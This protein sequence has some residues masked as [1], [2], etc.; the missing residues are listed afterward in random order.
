M[1]RYTAT[2]ALG[3]GVVNADT[4][5]TRLV[6]DQA[7]RLLQTIDPRG[8]ATTAI[9]DDYVTAYLYDGLGRLVLTVDALGNRTTT[10]YDDLGNRTVIAL[11][12]GLATTFVYDKRGLLISQS[13]TDTRNTVTTSDDIP[14]GT[15]IYQ[16]DDNGRLRL[17]TDPEGSETHYLYDEAGRLI[18]TLDPTGALAET[19]YDKAGNV[20]Q[21]IGYANRLSAST[22]ASLT[23]LNGNPVTFDAL[24]RDAL[25][26]E[27][28]TVEDRTSYT[29]YDTANRPV[30]VIDALGYVTQSFY[31]GAGRITD[32]VDYATATTTDLSLLTQLTPADIVIIED[33]ADDRHTRYFYDHGGNRIASLDAAGFL[34]EY[35]YD[36][37]GQRTE[38]I[39]YATRLADAGLHTNGTLEAIR[40]A[41]GTVAGDRRAY[42][43]YNARG[44]TAVAI[45][46][47]GYLTV[48]AYD[49]AG[50]RNYEARYTNPVTLTESSTLASLIQVASGPHDRVTTTVYTARNQVETVTV[51]TVS[52]A[53]GTG[54]VT[55]Y[56][57]DAVGNLIRTTR[58]L[59]T[60]EAR[61]TEA[62]YDVQA[63][64][65]GE[66]TGEGSAAL[67]QLWT[68]IPRKR[69]S[70]PC[71][72]NTA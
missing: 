48:W 31:D 3:N 29:L 14:L 59:N 4:A 52:G 17:I 54:T 5:T 12:N 62:R 7:G 63:N 50:N 33:A 35:R 65:I 67:A 37:A 23:D 8:E 19:V 22:I 41:I 6:Y 42:T 53:P 56:E 64:L 30:M 40:L 18:L 70:M 57:Y 15:T 9:S 13:E 49:T 39:G 46:A 21:S 16:Y 20:I 71:G 25:R 27:A 38:T 36:A 72:S 45:D 26:T 51:K 69:R 24:A 66:L 11:A 47:D 43:Y 68:A 2:D 28:S 55:D 32:V 58:A 60:A 34:I 44:Q 10:Y 1:T 61:T